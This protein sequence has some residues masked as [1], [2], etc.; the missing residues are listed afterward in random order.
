MNCALTPSCTPLLPTLI[1]QTTL[2]FVETL[3]FP[4]NLVET[5]GEEVIRKCRENNIGFICMKPLAGGALEDAALAMRFI[6]SNE[7]VDVIIPGMY[8]KDEVTMNV[9]AVSDKS[10]L[11]K[12]EIAEIERI[13]RELGTNFCRRCNYCLPCTV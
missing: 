1:P 9:S 10:P 2:D 12:E 8:C 4:Y 11:S 5:Q 6:A 7:N 13:R 3:M